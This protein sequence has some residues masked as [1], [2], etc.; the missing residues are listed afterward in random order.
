MPT[1]T[2][3][4]KVSVANMALSL[5]GA[6]SRISS[7][8]ENSAEAEQMRLWYEVS[9][10]QVL[11]AYDWPFARRRIALPLSAIDP[12]DQWGFR[13]DRLTDMIQMRY[14]WNPGG[15][16]LDALPFDQEQDDNGNLTIVT[17]VENAVAIYTAYDENIQN[18]NPLFAEALA[19]YL[20]S[21]I[22]FSLTG[23]QGIQS[24]M[25]QRYIAVMR[26]AHAVSA[27]EKVDKAPRDAEWIRNR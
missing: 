2:G 10:A 17:N 24:A 26:Y 11:Q 9:R 3:F 7:F 18:F 6:R 14:I 23:N 27:G 8:D 20:A 15:E 12:P 21:K 1:I 19:A 13:Y 25:E 16:D 5:I 4:S 22:A